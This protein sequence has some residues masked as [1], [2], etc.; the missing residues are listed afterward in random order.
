MPHLILPILNWGFPNFNPFFILWVRGEVPREAA[1][2]VPSPT[3]L[4]RAPPS[5]RRSG[6]RTT[7]R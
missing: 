7:T 1:T 6:L 2:L 3:P 4:R 5:A